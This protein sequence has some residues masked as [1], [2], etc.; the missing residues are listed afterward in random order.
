[1]KQ[2]QLK[3]SSR[4]SYE[5]K[6]KTSLPK[7]WRSSQNLKKKKTFLFN[8]NCYKLYKLFF[9]KQTQRNGCLGNWLPVNVLHEGMHY[10]S[11]CHFVLDIYL[12][13]HATWL[14]PLPVEAERPETLCCKKEKGRTLK[15]A[16]VQS[17]SRAKL[18]VMDLARRDCSLLFSTSKT[19]VSCSARK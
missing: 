15:A 6:M 16:D 19:G 10:S 1:M 5:H 8:S 9:K 18:P 11:S 4:C 14:P 2:K 13:P 7:F 3:Y 12:A 17:E